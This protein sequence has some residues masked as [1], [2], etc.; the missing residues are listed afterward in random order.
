MD[1][2]KNHIKDSLYIGLVLILVILYIFK[3]SH[4][5]ELSSLKKNVQELQQSIKLKEDSLKSIN[6]EISKVNN[7][8]DSL[9]AVYNSNKPKYV[10]IIKERKIK[11]SIIGTFDTYQLEQFFTERFNSS[12][13]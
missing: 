11:D 8:K 7:T 1:F 10:T 12:K 6:A 13:N 9:E 4:T 2:I 5:S 3:P